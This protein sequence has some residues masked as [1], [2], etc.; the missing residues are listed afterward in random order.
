M[1]EMNPQENFEST[2]T[3]GAFLPLLLLG[4]SF[5]LILIFQVSV[6]LPQRGALQKVVEHN[7]KGVEQS[8]QVQSGLQKLVMDLI[9]AAADDKDAQAIITKYGIQVSGSSPVPAGSPTASPS[10]KP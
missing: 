2:A 1:N 8:K 6:M 4:V 3:K 7:T 5:A 10:A 9:A